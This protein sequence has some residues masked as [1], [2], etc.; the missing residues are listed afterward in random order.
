[1]FAA[2]EEKALTDFEDDEKEQLCAL[3]AKINKNMRKKGDAV[4]GIF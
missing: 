2:I 4:T 3:L 1:M